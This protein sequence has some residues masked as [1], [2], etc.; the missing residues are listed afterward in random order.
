MTPLQ[1][2][3]LLVSCGVVA[4]LIVAACVG[5]ALMSLKGLDPENWE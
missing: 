3:A 5:M 1:S 4:V 2:V